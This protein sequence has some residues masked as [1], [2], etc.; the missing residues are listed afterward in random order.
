MTTVSDDLIEE[1]GDKGEL[2]H[3]LKLRDSHFRRLLEDN[4]ALWKEIQQIQKGIAPAED[5]ALETLE[6]R[7]LVVLDQIASAIANAQS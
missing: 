6:K 3:A 2:I 4:H 5:E 7:R 1:F